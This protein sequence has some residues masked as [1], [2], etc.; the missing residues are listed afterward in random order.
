MLQ[1][2]AGARSETL[3]R[4]S[5]ATLASTDLR[6]ENVLFI[7]LCLVRSICGSCCNAT[8]IELPARL[9]CYAPILL[10]IEVV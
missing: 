7:G 10:L 4:V 1:F 3:R 5:R 6:I 2:P 8:P 9:E